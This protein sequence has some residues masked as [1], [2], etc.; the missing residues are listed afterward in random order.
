MK[1]SKPINLLV[2]VIILFIS[3]SCIS[4]NT[5]ST[6]S[7][8]SNDYLKTIPSNANTVIISKENTTLDS[9][10]EEIFTV[11][12]ERGHRILK[13]DKERHYITTEGKDVGQSTL[14][15]MTIVISQNSKI[16]Q[17]KISTEWKAGTHAT[18]MA[19]SMSGLTVIADWAKSNWQPESRLGIAFAES[20]AI[21]KK[22]KN[23]K[24]TY[25]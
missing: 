24:V 3:K 8:L 5:V 11:L 4:I 6:T 15:R 19:N 21:A 17:A 16:T 13:D 1:L 9:L 7:G 2:V 25:E 10:Y 22:V 23:A 18:T 14:Q 20:V 12:L